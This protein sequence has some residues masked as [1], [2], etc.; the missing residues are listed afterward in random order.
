MDIV[1]NFSDEDEIEICSNVEEVD[2]VSTVVCQVYNKLNLSFILDLIVD[3]VYE[4]SSI[5]VKTLVK[6]VVSHFGYIVTYRKEWTKKQI[7]LAQIYVR[8]IVDRPER[9]HATRSIIRADTFHA[10][11]TPASMRARIPFS[12]PARPPT[13]HRVNQIYDHFSLEKTHFEL[14]QSKGSGKRPRLPSEGKPSPTRP[15]LPSEMM[16]DTLVYSFLRGCFRLPNHALK[17]LQVISNT[18]FANILAV[19]AA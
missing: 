17:G 11:G 12:A 8:D 13:T 4:Y 9:R 16:L 6:K 14:N 15:R 18:A 7:A 10:A 5:S 2:Y 1:G 19:R 3:L